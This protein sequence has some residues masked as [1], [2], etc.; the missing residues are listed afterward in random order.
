MNSKKLNCVEIFTD[1]ACKGNPGAGGWGA[2]LKYKDREKAIS[3]AERDT[4]N[5]RMELKAVIEALKLLRRRCYVVVY[6]DS[7]Y[8]KNGITLWIVNWKN[9][10]WRTSAK[11][12]VKN[13]ELWQELDALAQRHQ[14]N[15]QWVKGHSGHADN[16]RADQLAVKEANTLL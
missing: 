10:N 9:N 14:I 16:E 3:G 11:K 8:V 2:I 6:T 7:I 15:W 5:N 12:P 13:I 1:G 4:T